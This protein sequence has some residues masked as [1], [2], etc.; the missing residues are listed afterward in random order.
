MSFVASG[1]RGDDYILTIID[2]EVARR[3]CLVV[4]GSRRIKWKLIKANGWMS[5][6][7]FIYHIVFVSLPLWRQWLLSPAAAGTDSRRPAS[8]NYTAR[9]LCLLAA[10][11]CLYLGAKTKDS[12]KRLIML[13]L[14]ILFSYNL[15]TLHFI[16]VCRYL[17]KQKL[18]HCNSRLTRFNWI[19]KK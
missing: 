5:P 19:N 6:S 9:S 8:T 14:Q 11:C 18:V 1:T 16:F 12:A 13:I 7:D 10:Q 17:C 2:S 3:R 4:S 15:V